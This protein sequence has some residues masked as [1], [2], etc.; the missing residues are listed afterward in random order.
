LFY[1]FFPYFFYNI[2][3]LPLVNREVDI[4]PPL[5]SSPVLG[6]GIY[7]LL[8]VLLTTAFV[9]TLVVPLTL[10]VTFP[11]YYFF[12]YFAFVRFK[13]VNFG[14]SVLTLESANVDIVLLEEVDGFFAKPTVDVTVLFFYKMV[15]DAFVVLVLGATILLFVPFGSPIEDYCLIYLFSYCL[16]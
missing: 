10:D 11:F 8:P 1:T 6:L 2:E 5:L 13:L 12:Y 3:D 15:D 7:L 16:T 14:V 9:Y 4:V